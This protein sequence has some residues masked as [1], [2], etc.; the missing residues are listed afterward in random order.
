MR[1]ARIIG[2][3]VALILTASL[4]QALVSPA[5]AM[6]K[7]KHSIGHLRGGEV[8]HTDH[9]YIKGKVATFPKGRIRVLRNV[10]G[11]RYTVYKTTRTKSGGRFRT[12]I[13]QAGHKKTCF[14][15]QVPATKVY[16]RT[17]SRVIGCIES[18]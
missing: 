10:A 6:G 2:V 18:D 17:T 7:P 9:F 1:L 13:T 8:G 16:K 15:I 5:D 12:S 14:K 3:L 4:G 11:G